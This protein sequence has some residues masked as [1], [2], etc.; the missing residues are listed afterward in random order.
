MKS[1]FSDLNYDCMCIN[2]IFSFRK[3]KVHG[4]ESNKKKVNF[5][6][7]VQIRVWSLDN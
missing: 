6:S 7:D 4:D 1:V 2:D 5:K 3:K